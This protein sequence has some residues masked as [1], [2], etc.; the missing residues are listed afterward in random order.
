MV[1]CLQHS[2]LLLC[3]GGGSISIKSLKV[4]VDFA[5]I[6]DCFTISCLMQLEDVGFCQ[7]GEAGAFFERGDARLGGK[8]PVNTHGGLLSYSYRL[9]IE[10]LTEAVRQLRGEA[11][12]AQ[13]EDATIGVVTGLSVPDYGVLVLR[14]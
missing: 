14:Q 8:L 12:A 3:W 1:W 10:H 6:Y 7:K 2:G 13:V 9:G 5:E 11:G 4:D